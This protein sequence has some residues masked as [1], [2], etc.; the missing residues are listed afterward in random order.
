MTH[1]SESESVAQWELPPGHHVQVVLGPEPVDI[2]VSGCRDRLY[3]SHRGK[4]ILLDTHSGLPIHLPAQ[5]EDYAVAISLGGMARARIDATGDVPVTLSMALPQLPAEF[6]AQQLR[7]NM[8][9]ASGLD[10]ELISTDGNIHMLTTG[11]G[12]DPGKN[13]DCIF[14]SDPDVMGVLD[15]VSGGLESTKAVRILARAMESPVRLAMPM[16]RIFGKAMNELNDSIINPESGATAGIARRLSAM[17]L[18]EI[19]TVGDVRA[20]FLSMRTGYA[21]A[22]HDQVRDGFPNMLSRFGFAQRPA[23]ARI[24]YE[25]GDIALICSDGLTRFVGDRLIIDTLVHERLEEVP[26]ILCEHSLENQ[27]R[28]GGYWMYIG[29]ELQHIPNEANDDV[30]IGIM[31]LL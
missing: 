17:K 1:L 22:S 27:N 14:I 15:G 2:I 26:H 10:G 28:E 29:N 12:K 8:R 23:V 25:S 7:T 11:E 21:W 20:Y 13:Q 9:G 30:S 4:I 3:F 19:A 16:K 18:C 24:P 6:I 31:R 5:T